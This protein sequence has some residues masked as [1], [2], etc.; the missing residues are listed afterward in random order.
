MI[1][2]TD[3][4]KKIK[5]LEKKIRHL[6]YKIYFHEYHWNDESND[7]DARMNNIQYSQSDLDVDSDDEE[8]INWTKRELKKKEC[9]HN[10]KT[11]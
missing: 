8:Y 7:P 4:S 1:Q 11:V 6:K 10:L 2:M 5:E 9:K 3:Q